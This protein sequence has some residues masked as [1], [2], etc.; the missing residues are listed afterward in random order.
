MHYLR[1]ADGFVG[2]RIMRVKLTSQRTGTVGWLRKDATPTEHITEAAE[3]L[4]AAQAESMVSEYKA[5]LLGVTGRCRWTFEI[6]GDPV[7][8]FEVHT[9]APS[10]HQRKAG[11]ASAGAMVYSGA[12]AERDANAYAASYRVR[13]AG[14]PC[15]VRR[16]RA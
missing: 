11:H 15:F 13:H 12:D 16:V 8:T 10:W 1:S 2:R 4:T 14:H 5:T 3:S 6:V 7:V 9:G